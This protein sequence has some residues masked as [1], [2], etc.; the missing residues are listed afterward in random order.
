MSDL[1][2]LGI[3]IGIG[4]AAEEL[5]MFRSNANPEA[6]EARPRDPLPR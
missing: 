2:T 4:M 5:A 3:G 6:P 1:I